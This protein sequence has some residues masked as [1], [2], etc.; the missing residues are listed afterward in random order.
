[1]E[2]DDE[3]GPDAEIGECGGFSE[4]WTFWFFFGF[5]IAVFFPIIIA[6]RPFPGQRTAAPSAGGAAGDRTSGWQD[7]ASWPRPS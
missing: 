5:L 1:M 2:N 7:G 4:S 3:F 6:E